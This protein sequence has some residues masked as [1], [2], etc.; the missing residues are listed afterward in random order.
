MSE[1]MYILQVPDGDYV[2]GY[3]AGKTDTIKVHFKFT[4]DRK[5]AAEFR[6]SELIGKSTLG[7]QFVS[8]YSGGRMINI[9][10]QQQTG[11]TK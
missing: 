5:K 4:K 2:S 8:G 9:S 7:V 1:T 3:E 11:R 6:E 10:E